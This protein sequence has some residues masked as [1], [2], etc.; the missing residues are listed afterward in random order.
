MPSSSVSALGTL[1]MNQFDTDEPSWSSHAAKFCALL[2]QVAEFR[3]RQQAA[4]VQAAFN[5]WRCLTIMLRSHWQR[6][7]DLASRMRSRR[8]ADFL[9]EWQYQAAKT[10]YRSSAAS[11][12][13]KHKQCMQ[14]QALLDWQ[15]YSCKAALQRLAL[16]LMKRRN[17]HTASRYGLPVSLR[18][19]QSECCLVKTQGTW[20]TPQVAI[21]HDMLLFILLCCVVL[22]CAVLSC[23][24]LC[25]AG[26]G[27]AVPCGAMPFYAVP[28]CAGCDVLCCAA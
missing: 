4:Q 23:A 2:L 21:M 25:W 15:Y 16:P 3:L 28:C 18:A 12:L 9:L 8:L 13:Q 19:N 5:K 7:R 27:W 26:L 22:S 10:A 17:R 1:C 20:R 6:R 11:L 24:V 14:A